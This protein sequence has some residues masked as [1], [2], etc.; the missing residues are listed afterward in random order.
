MNMKSTLNQPKVLNAWCMYDWANSVYAL[1]IKSTIFP[2]YFANSTHHFYETDFVPF[3]G[4]TIKNSVLYSWSWALSFLVVALSIPLLSGI[5]DYQGS[6]KQFMRFFTLLGGI[7]CIGLFFFKGENVEFGFGMSVLASI[8]YSGGQVFYNAFLPEIASEDR[9]DSLSAKGYSIGYAGSLIL[10]ILNLIVINFPDTFGVTA[11]YASRL[12]FLTV[13]IWWIGFAQISFRRLP[14]GDKKNAS[15]SEQIWKGYRELTQVWKRLKDLSNMRWYLAGFFFWSMGIQTTM[16]MATFFGKSV[17][18][19]EDSNLIITVLLIQ[20]LAIIGSYLFAW[21][22]GRNGNKS[23]LYY[24]LFIWVAICVSATF[25]VFTAGQFYILACCTGLV[26]GG[27]QSLSRS[28]FSK[29]IPAGS[30]EYTSFFSFYDVSEKMATVVG[31]FTYGL[32][33]QL[34][35]SMRDS[36]MILGAYFVIGMVFLFFVR[37]TSRRVSAEI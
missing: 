15:F 34:T 30:P 16:Y 5:A 1:V 21:L 4:Y 2:I 12:A 29:L 24:Q 33:E 35:G 31:T 25:L 17:I 23:S 9:F 27:L 6:K 18:G 26:M 10:L 7:A 19:M 32:I 3:L 36:S 22:S 28:S 37:F 14:Q 11:G 20:I 8:G 13:G